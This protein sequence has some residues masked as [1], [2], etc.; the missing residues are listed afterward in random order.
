MENANQFML[1][2][3]TFASVGLN[4]CVNKKSP[5]VHLV[6]KF[7]ETIKQMEAD[8]TLQEILK[9]YQ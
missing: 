3:T 5:Y 1:L 9:R 6:P 8:G 4:L 7:D 2:P